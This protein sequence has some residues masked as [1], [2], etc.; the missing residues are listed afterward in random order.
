MNTKA[1]TNGKRNKMEVEPAPTEGRK[2]DTDA[3]CARFSAKAGWMKAEDILT[4]TVTVPING[5]PT[6]I[7]WNDFNPKKYAHHVD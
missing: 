3:K 2:G 1:K 4:V 6:P 7:E 5:K